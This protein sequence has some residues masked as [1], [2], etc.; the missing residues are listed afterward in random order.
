MRASEKEGTNMA[1]MSKIV[2]A[3]IAITVRDSRVA[4]QVDKCDCNCNHSRTYNRRLHR[5]RRSTC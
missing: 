2:G 4:A 3:V 5:I 1:N